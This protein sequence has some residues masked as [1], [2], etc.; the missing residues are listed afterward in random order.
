MKILFQPAA[1]LELQAAVDRYASED[2]QL[3]LEFLDE[4]DRILERIEENPYV[5]PSHHHGTRKAIPRR[6]PFLV[7][8]R[9]LEPEVIEIV[10]ITHQHRRPN[11]WKDRV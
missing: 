11:Y 7:I 10:A 9:L 6:F 4:I 5:F 8:F 1:G 2:P 3:A